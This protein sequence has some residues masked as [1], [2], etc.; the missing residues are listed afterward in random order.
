VVVIPRQAWVSLG[1]RLKTGHSWTGQ[2]RPFRVAE[3]GDVYFVA[4]S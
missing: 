4:S 3:T 2:N 1:G